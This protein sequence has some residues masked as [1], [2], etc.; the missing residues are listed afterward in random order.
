MKCQVNIVAQYEKEN[1]NISQSSIKD[2]SEKNTFRLPS[3][4]GTHGTHPVY[5]TFNVYDK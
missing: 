4:V 2:H 1:P 3:I 5:T